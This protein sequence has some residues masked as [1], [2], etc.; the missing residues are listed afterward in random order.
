[1]WDQEKDDR[2]KKCVAERDLKISELKKLRDLSNAEKNKKSGVVS[3]EPKE[4]GE[5]EGEGSPKQ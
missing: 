5:G 4:E 3:Q 1:M 2:Y